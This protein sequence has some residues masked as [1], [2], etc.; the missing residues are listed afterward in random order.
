MGFRSS[1][2]HQYDNG[3][4]QN[5]AHQALFKNHAGFPLGEEFSRADRI[6]SMV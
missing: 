3:H 6:V 5:A 4:A 1:C 2:G